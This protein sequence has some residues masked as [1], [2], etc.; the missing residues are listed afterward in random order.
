MLG[1]VH[2]TI[3]QMKEIGELELA[4]QGGTEKIEQLGEQGKVD[5]SMNELAAVEA[6][7]VE[8]SEKEVRSFG[9][10]APALCLHLS[11]SGSSKI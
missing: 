7:R 11:Y 10:F 1:D 6:L 8:K 9:H 3:L 4:I 5:E 2:N